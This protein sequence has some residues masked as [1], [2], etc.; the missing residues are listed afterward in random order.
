MQGG[1]QSLRQRSQLFGQIGEQHHTLP[2]ELPGKLLAKAGLELVGGEAIRLHVSVA[3]KPLPRLARAE[4]L[5]GIRNDCHIVVAIR[6]LKAP[7]R[8]GS[9]ACDS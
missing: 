9:S 7:V 2:A 8:L 1:C 4:R 5:W 6:V 3:G